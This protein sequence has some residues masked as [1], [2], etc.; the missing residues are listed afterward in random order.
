MKRG[1]EETK[2]GKDDRSKES[3]RKIGNIG[4]WWWSGKIRGRSEEISS[5]EIL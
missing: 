5:G 2:E 4:W 1:K 3:S